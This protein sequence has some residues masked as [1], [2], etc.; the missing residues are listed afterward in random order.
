MSG[1]K[2]RF[3]YAHRK[4]S[5]GYL[6]ALAERRKKPE[7]RYLSQRASAFRRQI[8]WRFQFQSWWKLWEES[9]KWHLRGRGPGTFCMCRKGDQ[10]PYS[11]DNCFIAESELNLFFG[12]YSRLTPRKKK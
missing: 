8:P 2:K 4:K 5:P 10:G 12:R 7:E 1:R 3:T 6:V 9:G 11:P